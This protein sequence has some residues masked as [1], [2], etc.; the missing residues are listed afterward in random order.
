[1]ITRKLILGVIAALP[2]VFVAN[3]ASG[4][5]PDDYDRALTVVGRDAQ[6]RARD[7]R[8]K[9]AEVL[10]FAGVTRGMVV[11]DVFGGG[12]YYAQLLATLVGPEG[13]V[14]LINNAP[15]AEF[16][17]DDLKRRFADGRLSEVDRRVVKNEDL[18]LPAGKVDLVLIVMSYHDLYYSGDGWPAIDAGQFLEQ[19]KTALKPG[20]AFVIVDHAARAGSG[21]SDAQTLH[22]IDE[23]FAVRDIESH[24]FV[25][26][27]RYTGLRNN[28]DARDKSVFDPSIRG[29][30]DR[31]VHRYR[32]PAAANNE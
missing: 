2:M 16:V 6:D 24:G 28:E 5:E 4:A 18:T 29:H 10:R 22:R 31:F 19:I 26:E 1:M 27:D 32:K 25:L 14:L 15:Y 7:E 17:A 21:K 3:L 20:G 11:A 8:D 13:Q 23:D 12:G 9:P 30:S